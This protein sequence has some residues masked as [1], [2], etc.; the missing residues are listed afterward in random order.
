MMGNFR[1]FEGREGVTGKRSGPF[2]RDAED[3]EDKHYRCSFWEPERTIL[4]SLSI[5]LWS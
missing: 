2:A 3:G 5:A 1:A 4:A